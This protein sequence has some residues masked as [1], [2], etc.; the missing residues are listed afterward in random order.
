[1]Q[2]NEAAQAQKQEQIR[3]LAQAWP[4]MTVD[5]RRAVLREAI[6]RI[7]IDGERIDISYRI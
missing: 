5:E 4:H 2:A 7:E 1:M 3:Q 6:E